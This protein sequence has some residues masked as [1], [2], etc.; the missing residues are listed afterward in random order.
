MALALEEWSSGLDY[1]DFELLSTRAGYYS[2]ETRRLKLI[3]MQAEYVK[4]GRT[5]TGDERAKCDA[6]ADIIQDE[7]DSMED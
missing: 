2:S 6:M 7:L 5:V 3:Q 4:K 1:E